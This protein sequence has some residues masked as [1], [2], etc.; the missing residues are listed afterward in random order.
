MIGVLLSVF[1]SWVGAASKLVI[2]KSWKII[3]GVKEEDDNVSREYGS[4]GVG[5]GVGWERVWGG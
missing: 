1:A 2:R 5:F 4:L 3:E